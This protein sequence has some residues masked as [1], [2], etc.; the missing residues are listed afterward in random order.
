MLFM[1]GSVR[2][3]SDLFLLK[4]HLGF[5]LTGKQE[6]SGKCNEKC[7]TVLNVIS[8]FVKD[9]SINELYSLESTG[10]VDPIQRSN[11]NNEHL[12]VIEEFKNSMKILPE[13]RYELCLPF[14]SDVIELPSNKELT[15]KQH[16]KMCE[17]AQRNGL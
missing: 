12:K 10:I 1:E 17:R 13:G 5:V 8:L 9:S 16:N 15:R 7:Y 4:T 11:E 3:D 14:K 6:V 2:L